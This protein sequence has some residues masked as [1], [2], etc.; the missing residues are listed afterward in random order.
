MRFRH[1]KGGLYELL[2]IGGEA[3]NADTGDR[4]VIYRR[5]TDGTL[6]VRSSAIFH[7][8][9]VV[10]GMLEPRFKREL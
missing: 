3:V 5:V 7:G 9:V 8:R 1:Y 2:D 4:M 10:G 6:W